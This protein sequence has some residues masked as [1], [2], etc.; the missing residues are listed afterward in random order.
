MT[1]GHPVHHQVVLP[2]GLGCESLGYTPRGRGGGISRFR[3]AHRG[4]GRCLLSVVPNA[5]KPASTGTCTRQPLEM[6]KLGGP[7]GASFRV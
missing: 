7:Q 3:L 1:A 4:Q 5:G 2:K 6:E